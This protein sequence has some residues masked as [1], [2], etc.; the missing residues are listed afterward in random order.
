VTGA[1]RDLRAEQ[2]HAEWHGWMD[3][4]GYDFADDSYQ[5]EAFAAG[6]HAE[7]DL[8]A[9]HETPP[10][11]DEHRGLWPALDAPGRYRAACSCGFGITGTPKEL[12][13]FGRDHDDSPRCRHVV[14][15]VDGGKRVDQPEVTAAPPAQPAPAS[16]HLGCAVCASG[17]TVPHGAGGTPGQAAPVQS[18]DLAAIAAFGAWI[19]QTDT[20]RVL[21]SWQ[22]RDDEHHA[23]RAVADAVR[24]ALAAQEPHAAPGPAGCECGHA[25][26]G[27]AFS[28]DVCAVPDCPCPGYRRTPRPPELADATAKSDRLEGQLEDVRNVITDM[29]AA[30]SPSG[31]GHTARVGQ[32]QIAKWRTRAGL[33]S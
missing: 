17:V 13:D 30:F 32:V 26:T 5:A 10:V 33:T 3:A 6:M 19:G 12:A 18:A 28:D 8:A 2:D 25:Q 24:M 31:S 9:V 23:W 4:Q 15:I 1:A 14:F 22:Q 20:A 29:L 21:L 27:H 16:P 7:R 11:T